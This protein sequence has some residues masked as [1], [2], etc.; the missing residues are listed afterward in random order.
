MSEAAATKIRQI[1]QT[2]CVLCAYRSHCGSHADIARTT[3]K[4]DYWL[5]RRLSVANELHAPR[6]LADVSSG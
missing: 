1:D 6:P 5:D 2:L 4:I 3:E